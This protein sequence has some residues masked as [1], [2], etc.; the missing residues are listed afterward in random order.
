MRK[1]SQGVQITLFA[2]VSLAILVLAL[3]AEPQRTLIVSG[4]SGELAV[5]EMGGRSYVEIEALT[6][7]VNGSLGFN[8]NQIVLTLPGAPASTTAAAS[9]ANGEAT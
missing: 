7:V 5:L 6:R 3:A 1:R 4:Y 2:V 9:S 8:G